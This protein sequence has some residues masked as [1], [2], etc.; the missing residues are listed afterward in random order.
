MGLVDKEL[1]NALLCRQIA[2]RPTVVLSKFPPDWAAFVGALSNSDA[3][4]R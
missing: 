4:D 2:L 3:Y 1:E